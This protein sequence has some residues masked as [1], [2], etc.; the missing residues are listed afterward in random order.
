MSTELDDVDRM[1]KKINMMMCK[2][3]IKDVDFASIEKM[4]DDI[5]RKRHFTEFEVWDFINNK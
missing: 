5:K 4:K 1:K 3:D 2:E